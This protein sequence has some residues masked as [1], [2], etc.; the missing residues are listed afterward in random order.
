MARSMRS[1]S[2]EGVP[3]GDRRERG[4]GRRPKPVVQLVLV[5][6]E[7]Q[8]PGHGLGEVAGRQLDQEHVAAIDG[9][10]RFLFDAHLAAGNRLVPVT[11][12]RDEVDLRRLLPGM[13]ASFAGA[14]L[15]ALSN[16][17]AHVQYYQTD[18]VPFVQ[19]LVDVGFEIVSSG[20]T[21]ATLN[22]AGIDVVSSEYATV[23]AEQ[24]ALERLAEAV[25]DQIVARLALYSARTAEPR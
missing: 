22:D 8:L 3:R 24:T 9:H 20:G 13:A 23:A 17:N 1:V 18:L 7:D 15:G 14:W 4:V 25:A 2:V 6:G 19:R 10:P 21:A 5:G 16:D 11:R 12:Y